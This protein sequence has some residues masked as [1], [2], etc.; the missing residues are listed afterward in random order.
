MIR[1]RYVPIDR[2]DAPDADVADDEDAYYADVADDDDDDD[3][4][5]RCAKKPRLCMID[6]TLLLDT[7]YEMQPRWELRPVAGEEWEDAAHIGGTDESAT[8]RDMWEQVSEQLVSEEMPEH[9][10]D[11]E[12]GDLTL[13]VRAVTGVRCRR[14]PQ[15]AVME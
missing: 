2:N 9:M 4:V 11:E 3:I 14:L 10:F 15:W 5:V 8:V 1:G 13:P 6:G 7:W 12:T